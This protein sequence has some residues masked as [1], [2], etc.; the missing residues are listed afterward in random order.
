MYAI[1]TRIDTQ[2]GPTATSETEDKDTMERLLLSW[3]TDVS[4]LGE[5][6]DVMRRRAHLAA[7]RE[8]SL[9]TADRV[10]RARMPSPWRVLTRGATAP[11]ADCAPAC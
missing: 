2:R 7:I 11:I 4:A 8:S 9:G 3:M 1:L 10:G 6:R 5:T